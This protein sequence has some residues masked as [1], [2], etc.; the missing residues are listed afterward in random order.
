[1]IVTTEFIYL[2]MNNGQ[3]VKINRTSSSILW[4]RVLGEIGEA[5][6]LSPDESFLLAGSFTS[7][8]AGNINLVKL[9]PSN[10]SVLAS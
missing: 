8:G 3:R 1:M 6:A 5:M 10:G 7:T 9:S 4:A 2:S